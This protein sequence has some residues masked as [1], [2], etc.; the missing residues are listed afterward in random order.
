MSD[1]LVMS[2]AMR[3]KYEQLLEA[4]R[5]YV[6]DRVTDGR[7]PLKPLTVLDG[8]PGKSIQV[9]GSAFDVVLDERVDPGRVLFVGGR[10]AFKAPM[11]VTN[12]DQETR[13]VWFDEAGPVAPPA[14]RQA[15][16]TIPN[17]ARAYF[18]DE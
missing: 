8:M 1:L 2:P 13:G 15:E 3:A 9:V 5:R 10:R 12:I 17:G 4:D 11:V 14:K 16:P 6:G 7:P 18:D